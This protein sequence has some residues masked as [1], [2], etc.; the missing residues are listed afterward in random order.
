MIR[1]K[2]KTILLVKM[3][4]NYLINIVVVDKKNLNFKDI[5]KIVL[6]QQNSNMKIY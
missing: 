1:K 6:I 2:I 3:T 5:V 4:K